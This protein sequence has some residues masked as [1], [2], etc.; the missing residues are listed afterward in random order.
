MF[1][2][3]IGIDDNGNAFEMWLDKAAIKFIIPEE[4]AIRIDGS[5]IKVDD[6]SMKDLLALLTNEAS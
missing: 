1:I 3:V 5:F 2:K 6:N 4:N